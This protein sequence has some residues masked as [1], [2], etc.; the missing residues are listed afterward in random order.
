MMTSTPRCISTTVWTTAPPS[1]TREAPWVRLVRPEVTAASWSARSC[2]NPAENA[3]G[4][5]SEDTTTACATSGTR[6]T[7]FVISQLRSWTGRPGVL[8]RAPL[9]AR[10]CRLL[11]VLWFLYSWVSSV[12]GSSFWGAAARASRTP[13]WKL[14][15][16]VRIRSADRAGGASSVLSPPPTDPG[17]RL[18]RGTRFG[19][20]AVVFSPAAG[21]AATRAARQPSS[22]GELQLCAE[23]EA[24]V[25]L[26]DLPLRRN[27]SDSRESKIGSR[28]S[29]AG[30]PDD[31]IVTWLPSEP[32]MPFP[33]FAPGPAVPA[34]P[35]SPPRAGI[36]VG[37]ASGPPG[38]PGAP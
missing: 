4:S 12:Y 25:E 18:A 33:P 16:R 24:A 15:I 37:P 38:A 9:L 3:S 34:D 17:T 36:H 28:W 11:L 32:P 1:N 22:A 14:A 13:R 19:S 27:Q 30:P 2:G 5:P 21:A 7:K 20:P 6:S 26:S 31:G 29:C 35:P 10:S 8:T 23:A